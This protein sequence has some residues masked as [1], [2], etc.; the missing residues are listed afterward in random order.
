MIFQPSEQNPCSSEY[1][2]TA[3]TKWGGEGRADV[4]AWEALCCVRHAVCLCD[5][6]T[7]RPWEQ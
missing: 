4:K 1:E 5:L 7:Q 3:S 2:M 6:D